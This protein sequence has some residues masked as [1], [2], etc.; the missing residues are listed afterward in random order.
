VKIIE[1]IPDVSWLKKFVIDGDF[2]RLEWNQIDLFVQ[3]S[4][5]LIT[6]SV[7]LADFI[8]FLRNYKSMDKSLYQTYAYKLS[9]KLW[10]TFSKIEGTR[11]SSD[12]FFQAKMMWVNMWFL[13]NYSHS[14]DIYA[15]NVNLSKILQDVQNSKWLA[16]NILRY[17]NE[18]NNYISVQY[19]DYAS[20]LWYTEWSPSQL[21]VL[22]ER[23]NQ[24]RWKITWTNVTLVPFTTF[25]IRNSSI[26]RWADKMNEFVDEFTRQ[27]NFREGGYQNAL[28]MHYWKSYKEYKATILFDEALKNSS[29]LS[30]VARTKWITNM[31]MET[32]PDFLDIM[33]WIDAVFAF[34]QGWSTHY[35]YIDY[36]VKRSEVSPTANKMRSKYE[37]RIDETEYEI[38]I[39]F[40]DLQWNPRRATNE[41]I[42]DI[43]LSFID[44][45]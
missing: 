45:Y 41:W 29:I 28:Y 1:D 12:V 15:T 11:F 43:L 17:R 33:W 40:S 7:K 18:L 42:Q 37:R 6:D 21:D 23:M 5:E 44:S 39:P 34:E 36:K 20:I 10:N 19:T 16:R 13:M 3:K 38:D 2:S 22:I 24:Q 9:R 26:S 27:V 4:T 14:W 8:D 30:S 32:A 31:R 25:D 35:I